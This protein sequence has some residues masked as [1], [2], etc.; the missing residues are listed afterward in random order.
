VVLES[1]TSSESDNLGVEDGLPDSDDDALFARRMV[2]E[3]RAAQEAFVARDEEVARRLANEEAIAAGLSMPEDVLDASVFQEATFDGFRPSSGSGS[4]AGTRRRS[5]PPSG[6]RRRVR[7]PRGRACERGESSG[8][9]RRGARG[10]VLRVSY[11]FMKWLDREDLRG[12][13]NDEL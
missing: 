10:G 12:S 3:E 4:F 2:D 13:D 5:G 9:A 6:A 8:S 1:E 11:P 7:M